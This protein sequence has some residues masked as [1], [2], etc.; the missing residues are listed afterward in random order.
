MHN[1]HNL[2]NEH[3]H[4]KIVVSWVRKHFPGIPF[5][6]IPNGGWRDPVVGARLR[7][8]GLL[9]GVPDLFLAQPSGQANG[10]FIEMK[11]KSGRVGGAQKILHE[12]LREAGYEVE[13]PVGWKAAIESVQRYLAC[14][15][16]DCPR[17]L[18]CRRYQPGGPARVLDSA[19]G[20]DDYQPTADERGDYE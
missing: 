8:E 6:S 12:Q 7:A 3:N 19:Y 1:L 20:C 10:L 11:S 4:Q 18:S 5:F 16:P 17:R 2:M 9:P 14:G 13:V 15:T